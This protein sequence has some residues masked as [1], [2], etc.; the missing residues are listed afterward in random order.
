MRSQIITSNDFFEKIYVRKIGYVTRQVHHINNKIST[1]IFRSYFSSQPT[2]GGIKLKKT[3]I[4]SIL[5]TLLLGGILYEKYFQSDKSEPTAIEQAY[6]FQM[7]ESNLDYMPS[8]T[9]YD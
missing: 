5:F 6:F 8:H 1:C 2:I 9:F 4:F 7:P 3:F